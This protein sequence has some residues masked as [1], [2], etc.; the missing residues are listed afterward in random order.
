MNERKIHI[1]TLERFSINF[2][3]FDC[4]KKMLRY[5]Y[6]EFGILNILSNYIAK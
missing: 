5:L 2:K 6:I 4:M 3:L 1:F